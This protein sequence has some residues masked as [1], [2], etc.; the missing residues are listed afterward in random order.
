LCIAAL[1]TVGLRKDVRYLPQLVKGA[2]HTNANVRVQAA[3]AIG[4]T[5]A[6]EAGPHLIEMLRD[7]SPEVRKAAQDALDQIAN[8]LDARAKWEQRFK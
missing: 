2:S 4:N 6:R 8:Y 5:F 3:Q 1:R 7:D